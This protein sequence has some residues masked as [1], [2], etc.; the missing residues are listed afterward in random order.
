MWMHLVALIQFDL[1]RGYG[2]AVVK[3]VTSQQEGSG[4]E[5][6]N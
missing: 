3:A 1:Y 6:A 4:Q 2:S 5:T